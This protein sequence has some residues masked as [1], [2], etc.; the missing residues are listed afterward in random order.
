M[1]LSEHVLADY[2]TIRLSLKA[3]PTQFLRPRFDAEGFTS[4][5]ERAMAER[6]RA[7]AL[8]RRGAGAPAAGRRQGHLH[9]PQR[10]DRHLQCGDVGAAPSS[11][12]AAK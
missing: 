7:G 2:H 10:R 6:R 5:A 9:H 8:R 11:V 1:P 4:C 12:S 3:Y